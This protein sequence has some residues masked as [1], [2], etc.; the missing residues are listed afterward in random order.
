MHRVL[1]SGPKYNCASSLSPL[2]CV[3]SPPSPCSA[4]RTNKVLACERENEIDHVSTCARHRVVVVGTREALL[5]CS[6]PWAD[7]SWCCGHGYKRTGEQCMS[8]C[9][10]YLPTASSALC[11]IYHH[12]YVTGAQRLCSLTF[13]LPHSSD[14]FSLFIW[15][16]G[17][18]DSS[19]C[20]TPLWHFWWHLRTCQWLLVKII[21]HTSPFNLPCVWSWKVQMCHFSLMNWKGHGG[22]P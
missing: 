11:T 12:H 1:T 2:I 13:T 5:L 14:R 6:G 15:C 19:S 10:S 21:L 8:F 20:F 16:G 9:V 22:V 17:T 7:A 18:S 3:P 4:T